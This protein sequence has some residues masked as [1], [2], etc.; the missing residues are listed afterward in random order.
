MAKD[1]RSEGDMSITALKPKGESKPIPLP[2]PLECQAGKFNKSS[3]ITVACQTALVCQRCHNCVHHCKC[4]KGVRVN[5]VH[6]RRP[7]NYRD[8]NQGQL[9]E[10]PTL[11]TVRAPTNQTPM[12]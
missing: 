8:P 1:Q 2:I 10:P 9:C 11:R 12:K 6:H 5:P 3:P 4:L 7:R